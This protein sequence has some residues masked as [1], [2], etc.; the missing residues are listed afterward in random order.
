MW[1]QRINGRKRKRAA[2]SQHRGKHGPE[3]VYDVEEEQRPVDLKPRNTGRRGGK[4]CT[5]LSGMMADRRQYSAAPAKWKNRPHT[6]GVRGDDK[7]RSPRCRA[8]SIVPTVD[9]DYPNP[10]APAFDKQTRP[11][12]AHRVDQSEPP[13]SRCAGRWWRSQ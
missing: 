4:F 11:C 10:L 1:P 7:A 9:I 6:L 8:L 12:G 2:L 5:N 3:A 13:L